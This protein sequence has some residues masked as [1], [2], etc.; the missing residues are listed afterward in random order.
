MAPADP[1][2]AARHPAAATLTRGFLFSDLRGSTAY[3]EAHGAAA[4][5]DLL[6]RYRILVRAA[7]ARHEGAE[8]KTEGD[9]FYVVFS[10]VSRAV[11]CALDIV[12]DAAVEAHDN[13]TAPIRAGVGVNAGE[14]VETA[15]GYVGTAVNLAARLCAAAAAGEVLVSQTVRDLTANTAGVRFEPAGKRRLKGI[16]EPVPVFRA[17]AADSPAT[18]RGTRVR[19]HSLPV[20]AGV[21]GAIA[22]VAA[23]G[24]LRLSASSGSSPSVHAS[25][26][27]RHVT[28]IVIPPYVEGSPEPS[29]V[30][31][32][33]GTYHLTAFKPAVTFSVTG[34]GWSA[35]EDR[36]DTFQLVR[37]GKGYLIGAYI[38]VVYTGP[39]VDSGTRLLDQTPHAL[40]QWLQSTPYL[41]VSDPQPVTV[42][43]YTG[44]SVEISQAGAVKA[45]AKGP[46]GRNA[47]FQVGD[48]VFWLLQDEEVTIVALDVSTKPVT[49]LVGAIDKSTYQSTVDEAQ[50]I[51][52]TMS[53]TP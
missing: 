22:I 25:A 30:P 28:D 12:Q 24:W 32:S 2:P 47:L 9:S 14:A 29:R 21:T 46:P 16:A 43:G 19:L 8:I 34:V 44:L 27:G 38:Q 17:V 37:P 31:L 42:G 18:K 33:T 50:V 20:V 10:S 35:V 6:G 3:T 39:C 53:I 36:P 1:S 48:H 51:I 49:L 45:C 23:F 4:G 5:A 7:V 40:V 26:S 11:N 13:P 41:R 15:E 52:R